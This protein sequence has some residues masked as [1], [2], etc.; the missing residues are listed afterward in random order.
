MS[1][2]LKVWALKCS[3]SSGAVVQR[4][5]VLS[6]RTTR[7]R[8]VALSRRALRGGCFGQQLLLGGGGERERAARPQVPI[9]DQVQWTVQVRR[10]PELAVVS[11]V[12]S[13]VVSL[14]TQKWTRSR[15]SK[16]TPCSPCR[17]RTVLL[18][19]ALE[20]LSPHWVKRIAWCP[21]RFGVRAWSVA[22]GG[23][24]CQKPRFELRLCSWG[25]SM[26]GATARVPRVRLPRARGS[27][28]R[29]LCVTGRWTPDLACGC[30]VCPPQ[31]PIGGPRYPRG[32]ISGIL[33]P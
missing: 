5:A 6:L 8:T 24:G 11:F 9:Q 33:L 18:H 30:W 29:E 32:G 14:L 3:C 28:P 22:I 21:S 25:G 12:G 31:R 19:G 26:C 27:G 20:P 10:P 7:R 17:N 23:Q 16:M 15:H 1:C 2:G 4:C 13:A